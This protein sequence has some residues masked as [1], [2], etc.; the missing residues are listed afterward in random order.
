MRRMFGKDEHGLGIS[1]LEIDRSQGWLEY[2]Q[3]LD[4]I[5]QADWS[6]ALVLLA[7]AETI[8]R[9]LDDPHGLW[10]ALIG[11]ALLHWREGMASLA[12]A[13]AMAALHA[14]EVADDGS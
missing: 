4:L 8:F 7:E 9:T 1:W 13:R 11:Q 2:R 5:E 14:A 3:A 10:R 6:R 12:I